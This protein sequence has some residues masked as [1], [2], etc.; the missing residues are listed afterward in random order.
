MTGNEG[1]I[2]RY[3]AAEIDAMLARGE[4][5]TDWARVDALTEEE[6]EASIDFEEE[7]EVD[8]DNIDIKVG[9][10][11]HAPLIRVDGDVLDFF[12]A[13]GPGYQTR[14]NQ[15]LRSYV[16]AHRGEESGGGREKRQAS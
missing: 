1:R 16:E 14:I 15:V 9:S 3:T 2:V 4:S 6:L 10:S 5:K 8:W 11:S 12:R 7:G 13:Q